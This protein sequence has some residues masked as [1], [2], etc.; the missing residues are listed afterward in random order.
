MSARAILEGFKESKIY[1]LL[2]NGKV[3]ALRVKSYNINTQSYEYYDFETKFVTSNENIRTFLKAQQSKFGE[4]QLKA[5]GTTLA[6]QDEIDGKINVIEFKDEANA[7]SILA[8]ITY[9]YK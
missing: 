3:V 1:K 5:V 4:L 2:Y 6:T 7:I 8:P 9:L